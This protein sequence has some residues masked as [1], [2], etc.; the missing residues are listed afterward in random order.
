MKFT[1]IASLALATVMALSMA[2]PAFAEDTYKNAGLSS[3]EIATANVSTGKIGDVFY[4]QT[5]QQ[6]NGAASSVVVVEVTAATNFKVTV[7]IALHVAMD[8]NGLITYADD[9][10]VMGV[11]AAKI[12][13][14]CPLGQVKI[15]NVQVVAADGW[16]LKAWNNDFANE[17]VNSPVFGF[18]INGLNAKA[19]GSL[20]G[21]TVATDTITSIVQD[22]ED[23]KEDIERVYTDYEFKYSGLTESSD[24]FSNHV[25]HSAF[26]VISN[27]S[28]L[29]IT[30]RAQLPAFSTA[31]TS[32]SIGAVVFTVDFN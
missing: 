3:T 8:G 21:F 5:N 32:T 29:P 18:Q 2:V 28:V 30:Y 23:G 15:S 6:P 11:G 20:D 16:S 31:K 9:M 1:K 25:E 10:S 22:D 24:E 12:I 13:N 4:N 7:P 17:K 27:K 26:P 14:E 19:D